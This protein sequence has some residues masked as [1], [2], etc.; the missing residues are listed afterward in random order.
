MNKR[1][2]YFSAEGYRRLARNPFVDKK[3][4]QFIKRKTPVDAVAAPAQPGD[5]KRREAPS[6]L[7]GRTV[8]SE[9]AARL[10]AIALK[11]MLNE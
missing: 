5:K 2:N 9:D 6:R 8:I 1:V 7:S 3:V 4:L 11:A 10:I